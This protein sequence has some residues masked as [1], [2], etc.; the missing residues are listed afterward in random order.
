MHRQDIAKIIYSHHIKKIKN[1]DQSNEK[2]FVLFSGVPGSGK[3]FLAKKIEE[4][5]KAVRINNDDI[6][7]IIRDKIAPLLDMAEIKPQ[8]L[9]EDYLKFLYESISKKN[10]LIILDSNMDRGFE[11]VRKVAHEYGYKIFLIRI[12]L[13]RETIESQIKQRTDKNP[14]PYI[15]DLDKQIEDHQRFSVEMSADFVISEANFDKFEDL[16]QAIQEKMEA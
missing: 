7:D 15:R 9:L 11:P 3:S 16:Y 8:E 10:G 1:F 5:F 13:P 4:K 12:D 2:M 14:E 6:R